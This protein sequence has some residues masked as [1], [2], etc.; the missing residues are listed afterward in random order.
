MSFKWRV[1]YEDGTAVGDADS[2]P[3][4]VPKSGVQA[5]VVADPATSYVILKGSDFYCYDPNWD[6]PVWRSMDDWGLQEY[7]R[8]PGPRLVVF[9]K[10]MGNH[11]YQALCTRIT[12][13]LGECQRYPHDKP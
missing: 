9:G 11:E 1:Y 8:E 7:M 2:E 6:C 10:W 12:A 3:W 4:Y 5:V 13:E